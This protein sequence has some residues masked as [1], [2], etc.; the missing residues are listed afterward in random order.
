MVIF[1]SYL[2]E[3]KDIFLKDIFLVKTQNEN[4]LEK[5]VKNRELEGIL[6]ML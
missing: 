2:C 5:E 4:T 6:E 3:H 1:R